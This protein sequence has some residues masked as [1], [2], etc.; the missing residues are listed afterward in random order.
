MSN[1]LY[2]DLEEISDT[3]VE[4]M[5]VRDEDSPVNL[6]SNTLMSNPM[7]CLGSMLF[8]VFMGVLIY[9]NFFAY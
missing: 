6:R 7:L 2:I 3:S 5:I 9:V 8:A 1:P 4:S